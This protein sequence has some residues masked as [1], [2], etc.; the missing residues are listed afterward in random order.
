MGAYYRAVISLTSR[1]MK[2][3]YRNR[4]QILITIVQPLVWLGLFG[5]A[6]QPFVVMRGFE[7][8]PEYFDFLSIGIVIAT[9]LTTSMTGGMSI[10]WDRRFGFL[11]KLRAAPIPRGAVP[12]SRILAATIKSV[13]QAVIVLA[14]ALL[15]GLE[16]HGISIVSIGILLFSVVCIALIF[17]SV[18]VALGL[19]IKSFDT[20]MTLNTLLNMPLMFVSGVMF[21]TERFPD[22]LRIVAD[23]NPLTY[24]ADAVRRTSL[25]PAWMGNGTL[26][27]PEIGLDGD[28]I[29]IA[30]VA[31]IAVTLG[32]AFARRALRQE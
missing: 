14:V 16:L 29:I 19:V 11:E 4:M 1:E 32:M 12:L 21:P 8:Y 7:S 9:A 3:W 26:S 31:V 20:Y 2:H 23:L 15:L 25:D 13:I 22:I 24:A 18:F 6:I 10:V 27:V 17:S 30:V 28:L 5:F